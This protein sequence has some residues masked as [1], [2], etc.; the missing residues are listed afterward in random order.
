MH[1]SNG[2]GSLRWSLRG[3]GDAGVNDHHHV[4]LA[5]ADHGSTVA[6]AVNASSAGR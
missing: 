3:Q 6:D 4:G 5:M 2:L 1:T